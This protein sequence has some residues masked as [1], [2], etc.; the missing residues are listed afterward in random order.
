MEH[1]GAE[2]NDI[3]THL[4]S[5]KMSPTRGILWQRPKECLELCLYD[6]RELVSATCCESLD[7]IS[8]L[9]EWSSPV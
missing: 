3:K 4:K 7:L 8:E 5:S 2:V 6:I 9:L 1:S